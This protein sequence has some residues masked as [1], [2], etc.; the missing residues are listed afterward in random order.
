MVYRLIHYEKCSVWWFRYV[1]STGDW[2]LRRFNS[3]MV[4]R[5]SSSLKYC[6]KARSSIIIPLRYSSRLKCLAEWERDEV[7]TKG[8]Q[9][10]R[11]MEQIYQII[12]L[13]RV[14]II[15]RSP[16]SVAR[17]CFRITV[18]RSSESLIRAERCSGH[19][20]AATRRE[21]SCNGPIAGERSEFFEF[22]CEHRA[23]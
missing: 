9:K 4:P 10:T 8:T 7:N 15:A 12:S 20:L 11:K 18:V 13:N 5:S 21:M 16:G 2:E 3:A 17:K 1:Q 19:S 22:V 14:V 23:A 6:I